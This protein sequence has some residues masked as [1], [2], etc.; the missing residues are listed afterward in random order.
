[1][2]RVSPDSPS[3]FLDWITLGVSVSVLELFVEMPPRGTL[4]LNMLI[5]ALVWNWENICEIKIFVVF[6]LSSFGAMCLFCVIVIWSNGSLGTLCRR[7]LI[8]IYLIAET[9]TLVIIFILLLRLSG[10]HL[11]P[12]NGAAPNLCALLEYSSCIYG[13]PNIIFTL[14]NHHKRCLKALYGFGVF[15]DS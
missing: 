9:Y 14:K 6:Q 12:N 4:L 7:C 10:F 8:N 11:H 1:M 3:V 5:S 13:L 2:N 15:V